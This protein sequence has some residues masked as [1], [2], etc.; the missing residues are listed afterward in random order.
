[1]SYPA[2]AARRLRNM[3]VPLDEYERTAMA[4]MI[5]TMENDLGRANNALQQIARQ[6]D[7]LGIRIEAGADLTIFLPRLIAEYVYQ[8]GSE[9]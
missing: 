2:I 9:Q 5:E 6:L 1:M 3:V 7:M 8:Q 4:N